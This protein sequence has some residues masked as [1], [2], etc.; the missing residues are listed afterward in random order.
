MEWHKFHAL[1]CLWS[2]RKFTVSALYIESP[3]KE[4][5]DLKSTARDF[6]ACIISRIIQL[7]IMGTLVCRLSVLAAHSW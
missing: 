4:R 6:T 7:G 5:Y 1:N 3:L 2:L